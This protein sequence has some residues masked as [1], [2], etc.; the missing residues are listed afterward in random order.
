MRIPFLIYDFALDLFKL[1]FFYYV[2]NSV[3][4]SVQYTFAQCAAV[5]THSS[6]IR[7]PENKK[8]FS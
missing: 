2:I 6:E 4:F 1:P 5:N 7:V 3:L 8:G